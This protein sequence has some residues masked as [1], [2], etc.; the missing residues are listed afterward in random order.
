MLLRYRKGDS[1]FRLTRV[2]AVIVDVLIQCLF[3][4]AKDIA[5]EVVGKLTL[6]VSLP[7]VDMEE[8]SFALIVI[9]T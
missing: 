4:Y 9:S 8:G 2:W 1:G 7:L 5:Y 3:D 6:C